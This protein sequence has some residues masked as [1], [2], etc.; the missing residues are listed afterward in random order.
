MVGIHFW[1]TL[2]TG[3]AFEISSMDNINDRCWGNT[4]GSL[5]GSIRPHNLG[6]TLITSAVRPDIDRC[7]FFQLMSNQ[8]DLSLY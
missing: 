8:L 2:H 7:E 1:M 3:D 6:F 5:W 4:S